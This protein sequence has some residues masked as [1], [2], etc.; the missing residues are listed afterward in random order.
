MRRV[1]RVFQTI[2]WKNVRGLKCFDGVRSLKE[3]GNL[4]LSTGLDETG[5]VIRRGILTPQAAGEK[6]NTAT[7]AAFA[8]KMR[9]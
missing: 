5:F 6:E 2:S 7:S 4:R 8:V 9:T 1:S 3:R